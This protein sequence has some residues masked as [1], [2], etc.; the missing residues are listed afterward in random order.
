MPSPVLTPLVVHTNRGSSGSPSCGWLVFTSVGF[1]I[2][3]VARIAPALC[4]FIYLFLY[5]FYNIVELLQASDFFCQP[6]LGRAGSPPQQRDSGCLSC[7]LRLSLPYSMSPFTLSLPPNSWSLACL[8]AELVEKH[9]HLLWCCS[10]FDIPT[11]SSQ[12]PIPEQNPKRAPLP[13]NA[14]LRP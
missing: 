5:F 9:N 2:L 10:A 8:A 11:C 7:W 6:F 12:P 1:C 13:A 14:A 4:K 3:V